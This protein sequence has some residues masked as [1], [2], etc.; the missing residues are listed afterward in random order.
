[1]EQT[2]QN[3]SVI[4]SVLPDQHPPRPPLQ[5]L[6]RE[7]PVGDGGAA[8]LPSISK[9]IDSLSP[10][11]GPT[12]PT[13]EI[14][15]QGHDPDPDPDPDPDQLQDQDPN[16]MTRTVV[17]PYRATAATFLHPSDRQRLT[18]SISPSP[19]QGSAV[20]IGAFSA[21][22]S[23]DHRGHSPPYIFSGSRGSTPGTSS[24]PTPSGDDEAA[25]RQHEEQ[26]A[27]TQA[28]AGSIIVDRDE[29][30][31]DA[32]YESDNATSASTSLA[33]SMRDYI[34]ENGRRYHRF[35]EGRYNFPNDDVEQQ[36]EDM[37]H[38]MVKMLCGNKLFYAP[39]GKSPQEILDI[40]TGTGIWAIES[41]S[42]DAN[43]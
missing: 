26:A 1:M 21:A 9:L 20:S 24:T 25:R 30:R 15:A 14:P 11:P 22:H 17:R 35:R 19:S 27:A 5:N 29:L 2:L 43:C 36:R 4:S 6:P 10:A 18:A 40:G 33:E 7:S 8:S 28:E 13:I 32:G 38:A 41:E 23:F 42:G 3:D 12:V 37:K 16:D 39:I 31:N 34:Y